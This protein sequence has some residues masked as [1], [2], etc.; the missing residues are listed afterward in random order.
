MGQSVCLSLS[1]SVSQ[2]CQLIS[3]N[4]SVAQSSISQSANQSISRSVSQLLNHSVTQSIRQSF[5][6]EPSASKSV[7]SVSQP[8]QSAC[9]NNQIKQKTIVTRG[10][11]YETLQVSKAKTKVL[12]KTNKQTKVLQFML[13]VL[14]PCTI[15]C[16]TFAPYG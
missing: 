13:K 3:Q 14:R 7:R 12:K 4:E 9:Q 16:F 2:K 15:S 10:T 11:G 5:S 6:E 1:Q 8:N